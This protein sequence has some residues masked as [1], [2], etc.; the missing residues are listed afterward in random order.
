MAWTQ[1]ST[2]ISDQIR[3][4]T[5]NIADAHLRQQVQ[6]WARAWD[7][8]APDLES[9]INELVLQAGDDRV[10]RRDVLRSK[11]LQRS[12]ETI[13]DELARLVD[14]SGQYVI[15]RLGDVVEHTGAM[16]E[17]LIAS[18]LPPSEQA[19]LNAWSRVSP[20]EIAAIVT[21]TTEQIT[22]A[23]YPLSDEAV[24]S[25]RRELV[26]GIATGT[27][28][29]TVA[30]RMVARTEGTFN[31]G[32]SRALTIARTEMLDA[33]RAAARLSEEANSDV[34]AGW[35]WLAS[36]SAR[37]CPACWGMNGTVHDTTE[38]GPDGHQNC[39]CTRGPKTKTWKDLGFDIPEPPSLLPDA[40]EAFAQLPV[41]DQ[42]AI[43]GPKRH[44][45]WK[46]GEFPRD[47]WA[48]RRTNPGWR[49]SVVPAKV[50]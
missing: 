17:R 24:A 22:K 25:M 1:T 3:A 43:L 36:L 19:T 11:R 5:N 35:V 45:A 18:Q 32:L 8:L 14:D 33:Q 2:S 6:A 28:P 38:S 31:G 40:D 47:Q 48:T 29:R 37:T 10:R 46:A 20:D 4:Q 15:D 7:D 13:Q 49:D 12:L 30:S 34:L 21:R 44:E 9:A 16:Q 42:R 27:N 50:A 23:S 26:R 41:A 39:R